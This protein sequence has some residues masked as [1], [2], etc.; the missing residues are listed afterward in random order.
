MRWVRL[1][2]LMWLLL[3]IDDNWDLVIIGGYD[4]EENCRIE[5]ERSLWGPRV[6]CASAKTRTMLQ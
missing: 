3:R 1:L 6:F 5:Q 2:L 4:T